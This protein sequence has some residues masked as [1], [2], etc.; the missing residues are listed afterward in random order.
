MQL[1]LKQHYVAFLDLLGFSHMVQADLRD[2]RQQ[3]LGKLFQCHQ[4][5]APIFSANA[6]CS[7]TQFSDSVVIAMPYN[8]TQFEWFATSVAAYQRLL[9]DE[10]LLCRGGIAINKHF[11]NGS[12]TFSAGLIEAY[13]VESTAARYPRVVV[14]PDA[15]GLIYPDRSS[16]PAFLVEE[17]DGLLFI[18]YLRLT[19]RRRPKHLGKKLAEIT[20]QLAKGSDPSI[21]EKGVWL[22]AYS[23]S[24]LGTSLSRPRF[25]H[26]GS[27]KTKQSTVHTKSRSA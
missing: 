11:S 6:E 18:D 3:F 8:K 24:V 20:G 1:D 9:L 19:A 10:G 14:S 27:T 12:F 4:A 13:H 21:R 2:Q 5:A 26:R 25:Q 7:I 15:L 17:D 22:A 16:I 23:D